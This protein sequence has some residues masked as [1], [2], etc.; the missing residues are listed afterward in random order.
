MENREVQYS[1]EPSGKVSIREDCT[2]KRFSPKIGYL[3]C[4]KGVFN[5]IVSP[6]VF[7]W[8]WRGGE[9]YFPLLGSLQGPCKLDS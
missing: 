7:L 3:R 4:Q 5:F 9:N 8:F 6:N 2:Y 1:T